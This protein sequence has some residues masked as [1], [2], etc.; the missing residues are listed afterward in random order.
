MALNLNDTVDPAINALAALIRGTL[1][2]RFADQVGGDV[3]NAVY[4]AP[5]PLSLLGRTQGTTLNIYRSRDADRDKGD[6]VYEESSVIRF[7]Y[8]LP[9]TTLET[10]DRRWPLLRNVWMAMLAVCRSGSDPEV[11]EGAPILRNAGLS[12]MVLGSAKIDYS[13]VPGVNQAYPMFRGEMTFIGCYPA[14][15]AHVTD[16]F[17]LD[18]FLKNATDW[19]LPP[20]GLNNTVEAQ[21][22]L[23]L[24]PSED[25]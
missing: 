7:D 13:F 21:N 3:I 22:E 19:N 10:L 14:P 16:A 11:A 6:W 1:N 25:P 20:D 8:F 9:A 24:P 18:D 17:G 4:G 15:D 12:Y 5:L 2:P 23:D